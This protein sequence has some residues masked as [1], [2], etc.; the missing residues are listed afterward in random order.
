VVI[1][2]Q[3]SYSFSVC[4]FPHLNLLLPIKLVTI[5]LLMMAPMAHIRHAEVMAL[6]PSAFC[7]T[8]LVRVTRHNSAVICTTVL[9]WRLSGQS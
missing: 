9:A 5:P 4:F 6:D 7:V 3:P 8:Q 2:K 1:F